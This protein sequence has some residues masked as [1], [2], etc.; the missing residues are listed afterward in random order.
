MLLTEHRTLQTETSKEGRVAVGIDPS[1]S[2]LQIALLSPEREVPRNYRL[3]LAPAS[4]NTLETFLEGRKAIFAIE[5]SASLG[6]L[7]LLDLLSRGYDLREL[8]PQVSKNVRQLFTEDHTDEKDAA[9]LAYAA[10]LV[11]SLP[12]VRLSLEQAAA[13]RLSRMRVRLVRDRTRYINRLH[14]CLTESYGA[15]YRSL[16]KEIASEKGLRFFREYPTINDAVNDP[17]EVCWE[18]GDKLWQTLETAGRWPEGVYLQTLRGEIRVLVSL[19]SELN[20]CLNQVEKEMEAANLGREV[21]VLTTMRGMGKVTACA[22]S[23]NTGH[24]SR[25]R[26]EDAYA[27]YC[28]LAPST[29]QSGS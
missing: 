21:E 15:T 7:F 20:H 28:G 10:R 8:Q 5:G 11:F 19:I 22:I 26:N 12:R 13:K 14:A 9:A 29:W 27:A 16:F 6:H 18:L 3:P 17:K 2:A 23:G 25:F 24:V 1:R 4:V